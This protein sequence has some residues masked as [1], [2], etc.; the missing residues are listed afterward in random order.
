MRYVNPFLTP[1]KGAEGIVFVPGKFWH[2]HRR[3]LPVEYNSDPEFHLG[4]KRDQELAKTV[5]KKKGGA[6]ALRAQAA[7]A[8]A[9]GSVEPTTPRRGGKNDTWVEV[10]SRSSVAPSAPVQDDERAI[11]PIST[12]SS[13]SEPPLAQRI[14]SN[15]VNHTPNS[16]SASAQAHGE[17]QEHV[18]DFSGPSTSLRHAPV[19]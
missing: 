2:R 10:P 3:P 13:A 9:E 19:S 5:A 11:S 18:P 12:T 1:R 14:R 17:L 7:A 6:A 8:Q 16:S 15:G 4:I